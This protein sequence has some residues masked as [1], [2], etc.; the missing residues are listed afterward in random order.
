[1]GRLFADEVV[2]SAAGAA[3]LEAFDG[4]V[5]LLD[6]EA[7]VGRILVRG[8]DYHG[9]GIDVDVAGAEEAGLLDLGFR[10]G[11]GG[12]VDH[13][14]CSPQALHN[15]GVASAMPKQSALNSDGDNNGLADGLH[16]SQWATV[17]GLGKGANLAELAGTNFLND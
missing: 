14:W 11:V 10:T 4:A 5:L 15:E 8:M 9:L 12:K 1:M 2:Y 3:V 17:K 13:S 7:V 16:F 6:D